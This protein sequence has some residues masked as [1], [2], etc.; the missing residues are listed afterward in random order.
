[1]FAID[2]RGT[3]ARVVDWLSEPS[4]RAA[5]VI[6]VVSIGSSLGRAFDV[7]VVDAWVTIGGFAVTA[8]LAA[9]KHRDDGGA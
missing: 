9:L 2:W 8:L 1:M 7:G 5:I 6:A 3:R 4:S